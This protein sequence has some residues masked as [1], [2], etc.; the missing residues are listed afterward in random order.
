MLKCVKVFFAKFWCFDH[1]K[2]PPEIG[3]ISLPAAAN[4]RPTNDQ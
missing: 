4:D 1:S 2:Y 3:K